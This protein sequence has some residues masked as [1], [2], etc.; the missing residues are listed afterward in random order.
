[1]DDERLR[2]GPPATHWSLIARA[3]DDRSSLRRPALEEIV[4]RYQPALRAHLLFRMRLDD[5]TA[6]DVLQGFLTDKLLERRFTLVA[7]PSKGRFRS[8]LVRSLENYAVDVLRRQRRTAARESLSSLAQEGGEDGLAISRSS[9]D[10]FSAA[11]ARQLLLRALRDMRDECRSQNCEARWSLFERRI[12][13]PI[14]EN[15]A[16]PAYEILL[17]E[18]H[19]ASPQQASNALVSAKRHFQRVLA[20]AIGE[21]SEGDEEIQAELTDLHAVLAA[22]GPLGVR[23]EQLDDLDAVFPWSPQASESSAEAKAMAGLFALEAPAE[24]AWSNEDYRGL[25]RHQLAQPLASVLSHADPA[26]RLS[27]PSGGIHTVAE[28]LRHPAPPLELLQAL[29]EAARSYVRA[30]NAEVPPEIATALYFTCIAIALA[31]RRQRISKS[32]DSVLIHGLTLLLT[33]TWLD[34]DTTLVLRSVL[35]ELREANAES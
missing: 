21:Y 7:D 24:S 20:Q 30:G 26:L 11:W 23:V 9:G 29:K 10:V 28:L 35:A 12:L 2:N 13:R 3:Q 8:L 14:L 4:R 32:A 33:R 15:E 22:A 25:W 16:P 27:A 34:D 19:F 18:F 1:M 17:A 31:A 6:D 5:A